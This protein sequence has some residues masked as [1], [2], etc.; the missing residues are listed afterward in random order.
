MH[1]TTLSRLRVYLVTDR[2]QTRGRPLVDV[3]ADA[4]RGG[5]RAVQ[6]RERGLET[7]ALLALAQQLRTL[8]RQHDALLLINDRIDIAL[9]CDA[10]GVHL[11]THSFTVTDAR[12]LVGP[13]RLIGVSTHHAQEV[14]AAARDGADF[15]VFG[16]VFHTPSKQ[17]YG[18]PVG[19]DALAAAAQAS[20]PVLAIGGVTADRVAA[21]RAR[22]AAGVAVVRDI[23]AADDPPAAAANLMRS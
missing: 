13:H 2:T 4:L 14:A 17:Q 8:T 19:L 22:G 9:A 10:D 3:V 11:P 15:A 6:L 1:S 18:P 5:V 23:L 21:L 12:A 20:I 7:R 16:P